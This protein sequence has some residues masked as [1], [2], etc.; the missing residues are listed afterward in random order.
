MKNKKV[1]IFSGA[2]ISAESGIRTFRDSDGLWEEYRIED[3][4]SVQ[5]WNADRQKVSDFYDA[6]R[7]DLESK[8]PNIDQYFKIRIYEPATVGVI[9][10][11]EMV[12]AFLEGV[13][14]RKLLN[15]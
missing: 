6:R 14:N 5:G 3:V 9:K 2:G 1:Y 15:I 4:C 13:V 11:V 8:D 12:E 10:V 7:A